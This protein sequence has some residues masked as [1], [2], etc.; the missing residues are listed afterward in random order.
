MRSPS[1]GGARR[2]GGTQVGKAPPWP[3]IVISGL[4]RGQ[5]FGEDQI[6]KSNDLPRPCRT[7]RPAPQAGCFVS[8]LSASKDSAQITLRHRAFRTVAIAPSSASA[9]GPPAAPLD[10]Y[11]MS[12]GLSHRLMGEEPVSCVDLAEELVPLST[13]VRNLITVDL[14]ED[15][16]L[17]LANPEKFSDT[18]QLGFQ[19]CCLYRRVMGY[20]G[21][22]CYKGGFGLSHAIFCAPWRNWHG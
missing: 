2:R 11:R 5:V 13:K 4:T 7:L 9:E 10:S 19:P 1:G 3:E 6:A 8:R 12:V 22:S 21:Y 15:F 18:R 14:R 17:L 20:R 16:D